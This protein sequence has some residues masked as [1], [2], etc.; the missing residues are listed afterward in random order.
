[1]TPQVAIS[2]NFLEAYARIPRQQ[3]KKV[4]TFMEKFKTDP[5]SNA[6]NYEKIHD[7][8]DERVRT[9]RIDQKYRAVVL[10]PDQG[11]IYVLMWVDN[12]DEAMDWAKNRSF[13]VNPATGSLQMFSVTDAEKA[14]GI[15]AEARPVE[16][17]EVGLLDNFSDDV[18]IS[19]GL[20]KLLLPAVRAIKQLATLQAL[21][22]HLPAEAAEAL[23]WLAEG[24]GV[25]EVRDALQ[26]TLETKSN[27][28]PAVDTTD[29]GKALE[30]PDSKRRFVTI[31]SDS[32]LIAILEAPLA[33]WRIF[34]HPSQDKL[35]RKSFNGPSRVLGG[36]GTGKTVVAM[37]RASFLAKCM[38]TDA[39]DRILFTTYTANLAQDVDENLKLL[40][41]KEYS[42]IECTHLHSWAVRLL[43]DRF[44]IN[45]VVATSS[46]LDKF[47]ENAIYSAEEFSF[48][49][50]F[51]RQEWETVIQENAITELSEYL[52][53]SR[54]GRG[55]VL[56]RPERAKVWS[57]FQ[58]YREAM[59]HNGRTEWTT[60]I[61]EARLRIEASGL[62]LPYKAVVVDEA[63]DFHA[64]EWKL[65]RCIVPPSNNDLFIVGDSHQRI[66][67]AQVVLSQSGINI[68]GRSSRLRIN[69]RTTEQIRKWSM[70]I[71]DGLP[72]DDLD[73]GVVEE[74]GYRSLLSG[75]PPQVFR[76]DSV[77]EETDFL[78]QQLR[79]IL[80]TRSP[81]DICIVA[82][83]NQPLKDVYRP[84]LRELNIKHTLLDKENHHTGVALATM[85]RVKGLEFPV[86]ILAGTNDN[87][88]PLSVKGIGSDP[89]ALKEHLRRERSL[90]FVA[91]TR[92]RDLLF[93]TSSGNLSRFVQANT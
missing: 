42:K 72:Y 7:V 83:T 84:L 9:V 33:K 51:L 57:V 32:E 53:V 82:R 78:S 73:G 16:G 86:V 45:Y 14:I 41:G 56:S 58:R 8:R 61:R 12:H 10:H 20:P 36:P 15:P 47:W 37:H 13:E 31:E 4:R 75:P 76:F 27:S 68:R 40:C 90:F 74:K 49:P 62:K 71:L 92:A 19:F 65:I 55:V 3:Q 69:Y 91:A 25:E 77:K 81:E 38:C 39:T 28:K 52:K 89:A 50:G 43:R 11:D 17:V 34:L 87:V 1:M 35:V 23:Y 5:K 70:A 24:L 6:I 64:E 21:S 67:G 80:E 54:R 26:S 59:A 29:I 18:L 88:M 44:K 60:V 46:E 48:E 93:I 85:H 30:H 22:L 79:E 63:Q 2:D 66:Y